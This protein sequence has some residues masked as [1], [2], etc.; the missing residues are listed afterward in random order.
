MNEALNNDTRP[1]QRRKLDSRGDAFLIATP[2]SD[3]PEG[4][5]RWTLRLLVDRLVEL[6]VVESKSYETVRRTPKKTNLSLGKRK[7]GLFQRLAQQT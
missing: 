2:C 1:G 4:H 6:A 3:A 5:D 7:C